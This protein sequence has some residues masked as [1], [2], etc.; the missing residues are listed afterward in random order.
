MDFARILAFS[1]A[2]AALAGAAAFARRRRNAADGS[3]ARRI[4]HSTALFALAIGIS[5]AVEPDPTPLL[6]AFVAMGILFGGAVGLPAILILDFGAQRLRPVRDRRWLI[7][8]PIL[9]GAGLFALLVV[10]LAFVVDDGA[11]LLLVG[12]RCLRARAQ[13][14]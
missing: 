13:G 4:W 14:C 10:P 7:A 2:L 6:V 9:F 1:V 11:D 3:R 8:A 5:S 12:F